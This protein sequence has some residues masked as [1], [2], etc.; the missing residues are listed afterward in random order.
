MQKVYK[1]CNIQGQNHFNLSGTD[2]MSRSIKHKGDFLFSTCQSSCV[3]S[4]RQTH[5]GLERLLVA[6]GRDGETERC[7]DRQ[8]EMRDQTAASVCF[9]FLMNKVPHISMLW[10]SLRGLR[11]GGGIQPATRPP[12][13]AT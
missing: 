7:R 1:K 2:E 11:A 12:L 8:A 13:R 5:G 10:S 4:V 9:I 6:S 3:V